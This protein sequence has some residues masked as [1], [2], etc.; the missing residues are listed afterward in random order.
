MFTQ[1]DPRALLPLLQQPYAEVVSDLRNALRRCPQ[2]DV[3]PDL[4]S[5]RCPVALALGCRSPFW[6]ER[7]MDWV[8]DGFPLDPELVRELREVGGDRRFSQ[9]ARHRAIR[10]VRKWEL[11]GK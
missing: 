11:S 9:A 1:P 3:D 10:L 2:P 7:A 8:E 6:V 4:V 5:L